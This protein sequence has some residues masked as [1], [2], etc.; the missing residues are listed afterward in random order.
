MFGQLSCLV[1][2]RLEEATADGCTLEVRELSV[3]EGARGPM[4]L[5]NGSGN[6]VETQIKL[7]K[8]TPLA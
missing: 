4:A 7:F 5:V 1:V 6:L 8:V 3:V 2:L